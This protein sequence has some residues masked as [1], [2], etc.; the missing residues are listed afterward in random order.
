[1][2]PRIV[3]PAAQVID[4]ARAK[5]QCKITSSDRDEDVADAIAAARDFAQS[6]LGVPVGEQVLEYTYAQWQGS[7]ELPCDVTNLLAVSAAGVPVAPLPVLAG[8]TL[9]LAAAAPVVVRIRCGYTAET[10]P[11]TVKQAM[12]LFIA[13]MVR[14]PSAQTETQL[15]RNN[16]LAH[17]LWP[18][19]ERL[20]L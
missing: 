17:L 20:P 18:H 12:L 14:N 11:A 6:E 4:L 13:D 1:M 9:T 3:E 19:R 7:V 8:R 10:L 2:N 5:L 16:A 15:Y